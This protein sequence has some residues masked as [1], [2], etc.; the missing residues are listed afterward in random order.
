MG[1]LPCRFII[2]MRSSI[3]RTRI[4][5]RQTS[6]RSAAV[7]PSGRSWLLLIAETTAMSLSASVTLAWV[8][9]LVISWRHKRKSAA[10][11]ADGNDR[12]TGAGVANVD[13][14]TRAV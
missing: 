7:R 14:D 12:P 4:I 8:I 13:C 9:G 2:Q 6:T 5:C 10:R 11:A 3:A 1:T